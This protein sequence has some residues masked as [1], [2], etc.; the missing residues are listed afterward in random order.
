[1]KKIV[2]VVLMLTMVFALL[3]ACSGNEGAEPSKA[4]APTKNTQAASEPQKDGP[5][6][7]LR[8]ATNYVANQPMG[9]MQQQILD[10]FKRDF[11]NVTIAMEESAGND[12]QTKIKMD[13][14]S[15]RIPD[16][17][18]YW[19]MDPV[20]GL[21][22]I[23]K[24][25]QLADLS[26]W[27]KS[28]P[29]FKDL[30]DDDF[31]KTATLE[32]KTYGVPIVMYFMQMFVNKE[33]LDKAGIAVPQTFEELLAATKALK[34][35]GYVPWGINTQADSL[36]NRLYNYVMNGMLTNERALK[37][38]SGQ[39]S[40]NVPEVVKAL[41]LL[42]ELVVGN[43]P[44]DAVA[45]N[46]DAVISKYINTEKSALFESGS[47]STPLIKP[48]IQAKMVAIDFPLIPDGAQKTKTIEKD[49]TNLYYVSAKSWA[50]TDK[51]PYIQE[52]L[53]RLTSREAGKSY[54]EK[55]GQNIPMKGVEVDPVKI[56]RLAFDAQKLTAKLPANKWLNAVMKPDQRTKFESKMGA[57]YG[58]QITPEKLAEDLNAIFY[59]K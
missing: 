11:P 25:G 46:T 32:G 54:A 27:V 48:E 19:R 33:I 18:N 5:K 22:G 15:D 39:E 44:E 28:D 53:R 52:L 13:A 6:V 14:V 45:L 21:D 38:H 41:T 40:M 36:A 17:F 30:F 57:F 37:M 51:R 7:T 47:F 31:W 8:F 43:I 50:D 1:M 42:K 29:A 2:S 10:Q 20:F 23:A 59:S 58:G 49:L 9:P 4:S 16:V 26:D 12:L 3:A 35:K 24:A 55:A 34:A 56:G